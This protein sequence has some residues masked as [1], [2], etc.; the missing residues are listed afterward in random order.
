VL[1]AQVTARLIADRAEG[2]GAIAMLCGAGLD[3]A[4]DSALTAAA[5]NGQVEGADPPGLMALPYFAR[6]DPRDPMVFP[7]EHADI[8][9][10]FPPSLLVTGS[11]DFAASS[12]TM[13][14]RRL[15]G[16]GVDAELLHF[17]GMWHAH[18]MATTLAE[19]RETF[20]AIARFFDQKLA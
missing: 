20:A 4:G 17:D 7:G 13:M 5:L 8:L 9:A 6:C 15:R 3:M 1:T 2:P 10:R 12:V 19:S 11:R 18:H 16:V 14:H